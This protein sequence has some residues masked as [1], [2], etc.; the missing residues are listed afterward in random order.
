MFRGFNRLNYLPI[1][2][3]IT[4]FLFLFL[5]GTVS[6]FSQFTATTSI[7]A[8]QEDWNSAGAWSFPAGFTPFEG[9]PNRDFDEDASTAVFNGDYGQFL[10]IDTNDNIKIPN[11]TT[12]DLRNSG[13]T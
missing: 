5:S 8:L 2:M 4:F 7:G 12:I 13:I 1:S 9:F 6:G 11:N 3:R 10:I